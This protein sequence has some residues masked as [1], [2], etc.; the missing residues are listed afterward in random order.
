MSE[1][2]MI[3]RGQY[4]RKKMQTPSVQN[5]KKPD[6]KFLKKIKDNAV[7]HCGW[8]RLIFGQ[9]F[10]E[11][12]QILEELRREA[13]GERDIAFYVQDPHVILSMAPAE[14]FLDPSHTFRI[15]F[16]NY[17]VSSQTHPQITVRRLRGKKDIE[18]V[19]EILLSRGMIPLNPKKAEEKR[20]SRAVLGLVAEQNSTGEIVGFVNGVDHAMAFNDP[21]GGSSLWSLAVSINCN[22]PKVGEAL[23]RYLIEHFM[24]RGRSFLD[25]SVIH[26]NKEAIGLYKKLKFERVPV[27]CL[28]LKTAFNEPLFAGPRADKL[29]LNPYAQ[30][31]INE[32]RRRGIMVEVQDNES[33]FFRLSW[34][35]RSI[36]CRESLTDQTS[37]VAMSR[38]MDKR[39]TA[40]ILKKNGVRVPD[41]IQ[42]STHSEAEKF[43][44]KHKNL[45]IKPAHG[46]QGH[47][48]K[49]GIKTKKALKDS[50]EELKSS[51]EPLILEEFVGGHDVRIIIIN[52]EFVAAA[53]R[54]PPEI[55]GDG[56]TTIK[57]LINKLSRRRSAATA[58]ESKIPLDEDTLKCVSEAKYSLDDV[59]PM[60][61]VL[62]VRKTAN[63]HT[64]G[65]IVDIT[66]Q[67]SDE[68]K[69]IS[70][71]AARILETPVV[72]L[73]LMMPQM[74][75]SKYWVIE[76]NERPGLANHE[77]Q[78]TAERF[79]DMLFPLTKTTK[80]QELK[81]E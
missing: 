51:G 17:R 21:E 76:A 39:V 5:W 69:E 6:D 30:I 71:R 45:V 48:V 11:P 26:M 1:H 64:G 67:I 81:R 73:D 74:T 55:V 62:Q 78:P 68:I 33:A 31:I 24:A 77:P 59:L 52:Y 70:V 29:K 57:S 47:G 66:N 36:Q 61:N 38:C 3:S 4:R 56:K 41:Q 28:K 2:F 14:V 60:G 80:D 72:G 18:K 8:G 19:N 43:L 50:L 46:E 16:E 12:V 13:R 23:T 15:W 75:G 42:Y 22:I 34:G 53:V 7:I 49:I 79:I 58:G 40:R 44:A 54:K 65:S 35:G 20:S 63:V 10:Y 25:L 27:F 37:A 32:A 9:T